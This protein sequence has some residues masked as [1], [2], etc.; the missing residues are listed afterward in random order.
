MVGRWIGIV[1]GCTMIGLVVGL[2]VG[3][4]MAS[5]APGF[6]FALFGEQARTYGTPARELCLGLGIANGPL[7]GLLGG[8]GV[9]VS[10]AIYRT[11]KFP[12]SK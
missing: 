12:E 7:L 10:E 4:L 8:I 3:L 2:L 6:A 11:R 1:F 9:I 5:L